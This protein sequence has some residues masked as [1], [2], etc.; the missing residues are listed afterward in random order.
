MAEPE[1]ADIQVSSSK[2]QDQPW[3]VV[4]VF[5]ILVYV[6]IIYGDVPVFLMWEQDILEWV[7]SSN[8]SGRETLPGYTVTVQ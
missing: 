6:S 5:T 8:I 7:W 1:P 2:L 3:L 4:Q